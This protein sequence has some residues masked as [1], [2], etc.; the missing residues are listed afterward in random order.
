MACN[1][2]E[3]YC[4][5][6]DGN[7][8]RQCTLLL[9]E[10]KAHTLPLRGLGDW[11]GHCRAQSFSLLPHQM[12]PAIL[13]SLKSGILFCKS[14]WTMYCKSKSQLKHSPTYVLLRQRIASGLYSLLPSQDLGAPVCLHAMRLRIR[15]FA[16]AGMS[17]NNAIDIHQVFTEY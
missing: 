12:Q 5:Q 7:M 13:F 14:A 3:P 8:N 1:A 2:L 11:R 17:D 6:E 16:E 10:N 9:M 4:H 15:S